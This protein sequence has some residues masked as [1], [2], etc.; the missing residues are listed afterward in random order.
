MSKLRFR[1]LRHEELWTAAQVIEQSVSVI[2]AAYN[3]TPDSKTW[4][5]YPGAAEAVSNMEAA[6]EDIIEAVSADPV[7]SRERDVIVEAVSGIED[8]L[9]AAMYGSLYDDPHSRYLHIAIGEPR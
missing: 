5:Q 3:A 9:R 1:D 8:W 6:L 7:G 2:Y 4:G